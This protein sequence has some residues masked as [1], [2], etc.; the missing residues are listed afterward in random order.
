[1]RPAGGSGLPEAEDVH[2][3]IW[4]NGTA[5]DYRATVA[6]ASQLMRDWRQRRWCAIEF[7]ANTVEE[8]MPMTRLP[9]ERL[10]LGP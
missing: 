7:I 1:M 4:L 5:L 10:F 9:N 6:A 8:C 2:L 3:R